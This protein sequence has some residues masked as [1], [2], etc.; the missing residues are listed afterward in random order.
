MDERGGQIEP[1]AHPARVGAHEPAGGIG[2]A[3][4]VEQLIGTGCDPGTRKVG[5]APDQHQVLA[6]GQ[7]A[8]DRR[9][10]PGKA[11]PATHLVWLPSHVEAEHPRLA[12]IG[13]EDGAQDPHG[14]RLP[15][16]VGAEQAEDRPLVNRQVDA[17][18]RE[19]VAEALLETA[20]ADRC[21]VHE[22]GSLHFAI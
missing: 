17:G 6:A 21:L 22:R 16:A 1:P 9:V 13:L 15:G 18:Q 3:E 5:Q 12:C 11:D 14:G 2:Q 19:N 7:V 10:L 4:A 8:V 20:Y